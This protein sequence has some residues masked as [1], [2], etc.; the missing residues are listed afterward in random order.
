MSLYEI[1]QAIQDLSK[2]EFLS[3]KDFVLQ[4]DAVQ[5]P[6]P[7]TESELRQNIEALLQNAKPA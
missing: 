1:M 6:I 2:E 3:L 7:M 4:Q 5:S